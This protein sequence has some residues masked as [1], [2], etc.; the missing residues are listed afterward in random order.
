MNEE[1]E[2]L[3]RALLMRML[4]DT[5]GL[6]LAMA[7]IGNLHMARLELADAVEKLNQI[8]A[9]EAVASTPAALAPALEV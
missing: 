5:L 9:L 7:K 3:E 8:E 2:S 1:M 4:E 6:A